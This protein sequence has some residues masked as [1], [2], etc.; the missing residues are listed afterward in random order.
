M[1]R[2]TKKAVLGHMAEVER[3]LRR[4]W[5]I[6]SNGV[7]GGLLDRLRILAEELTEAVKDHG[8]DVKSVLAN[9]MNFRKA[10]KRGDK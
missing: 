1:D 3:L 10:K 5:A 6:E 9:Q 7:I 2:T 8:A 4:E